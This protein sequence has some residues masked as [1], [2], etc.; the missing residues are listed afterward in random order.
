MLKKLLA[1]T[2][3]FTCAVSAQAQTLPTQLLPLRAQTG[4]HA[5]S[6]ATSLN[7]EQFTTIS[8]LQETLA[9][10]YSGGAWVDVSRNV[11]LRY[12]TTTLPGLVRIDKKSG[13]SWVVSAAHRFRYTTAGEI[14]SDTLDQYQ[15]AP[16]G[17]YTAVVGAF[18]TPSQVRRQWQTLHPPGSTAPWDS[19][20]RYTYTYNALGQRT[21]ELEELYFMDSFDVAA[22]HLW[23]YNAKGQVAVAEIQTAPNGTPDWG[24]LQR[25][26]Y[27]YNAAGKVQQIVNE[28]AGVSG[29]VYFNSSRSTFQFDAQGRESVLTTDSW[30]NNAWKVASQ[31]LYAYNATSDPVSAT[32]QLWNGSSFQNYQ[33]LLLTYQQVLGAQSAAGRRLLAVV[34][35]PTTSAPAQL[36]LE[37]GMAAATGGVYDQLG[38][39]VAQLTVTPAQAACGSLA[40]PASLPAGL[41]IVRLHTATRQFQAR[42]DKR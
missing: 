24:L 31:T 32:A 10:S 33:R 37:A 21:Q 30:E 29:T 4:T 38:R 14:L 16:Y 23:T 40:L 42:W 12:R 17:P 3:G 26:T 6:A 2:T 15:Q 18:T 9:Q 11:Y 7:V 41:Y 19:V 8:Q 25:A 39:Q 34:P 22:R 1:L 13:A 27:T 28:M 36:Q 35:N 5:A 20:H